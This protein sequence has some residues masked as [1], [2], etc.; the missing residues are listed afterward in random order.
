M[1]TT[2]IP[3]TNRPLSPVTVESAF[4]ARW[5]RLAPAS[6]VTGTVTSVG[7]CPRAAVP[8][9][10]RGRLS[11]SSP[12]VVLAQWLWAPVSVS[13]MNRRNRGPKPY[14]MGGRRGWQPALALSAHTAPPSARP[15]GLRRVVRSWGVDHPRAADARRVH[16][17]WTASPPMPSPAARDPG[18]AARASPGPG[19]DLGRRARPGRAGWPR[20]SQVHVMQPRSAHGPQKRSRRVRRARLA[21]CS[22]TI[23]LL[24]VIPKSAATCP[25]GSPCR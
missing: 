12:P 25:E 11:Y 8:S 17:R 3:R 16:R 20:H 10:V 5:M 14:T 1:P 6:P 21:R 19:A 22:R 13:F 9:W 4:S 15:G 23:R 2:S 7:P 24:R 18:A